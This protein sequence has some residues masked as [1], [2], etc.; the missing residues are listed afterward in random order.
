MQRAEGETVSYPIAK[1]KD[2]K[3]CGHNVKTLACVHQTCGLGTFY[4]C[5]SA[6]LAKHMVQT[7]A[8]NAECRFVTEVPN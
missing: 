3:D 7:R 5:S 2:T 8:C 4:A 1:S 6:C